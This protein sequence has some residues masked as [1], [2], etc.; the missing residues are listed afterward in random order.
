MK[1]LF[2]CVCRVTLIVG[3]IVAAWGICLLPLLLV[4]WLVCAVMAVILAM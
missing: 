4:K 3:A 2:S 1:E